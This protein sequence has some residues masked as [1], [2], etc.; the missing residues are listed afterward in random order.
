MHTIDNKTHPV[1]TS[2]CWVLFVLFGFRLVWCHACSYRW[3]SLLRDNRK[4]SSL[5]DE[6]DPM[7]L[8]Q[9]TVMGR[10]INR[11]MVDT[12]V[13]IVSHFMVVFIP[14]MLYTTDGWCQRYWTCLQKKFIST[15]LTKQSSISKTNCT[16]YNSNVT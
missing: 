3:S 11:A 15:M 16:H 4:I 5:E 2:V 10:P 9:E 13:S 7:Y 14:T 6:T 1:P 12:L 8:I